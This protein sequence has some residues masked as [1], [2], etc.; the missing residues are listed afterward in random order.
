MARE[1][2]LT[3]NGTPRS[4]TTDGERP[5]LDVLREDFHLTGTKYGCG[6]GECGACTVLVGGKPRYACLTAIEE[7]DGEEVLTIEGLAD[8]GRL[9]TVQQAFLDQQGLQ[10][11]YCVPGHIMRAVAFCRDQP[12]ASREEVV[13]AMSEHICRCCNYPNI[14][15]AVE[16]A[17]RSS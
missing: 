13:A 11:G 9:H 7:V 6:E 10:C 3:V 16:Q 1:I 17:V 4:T 12:G 5:L 2:S 14:L 15:A 8:A